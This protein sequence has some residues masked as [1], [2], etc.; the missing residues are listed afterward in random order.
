MNNVIWKPIKGYEGLYEISSTGQIK[1]LPRKKGLKNGHYYITKEKILKT[2]MTTTGYRKIELT[3][4]GTKK[5]KKVHRLIAKAFIP[6]EEG[7]PNINHIDGNQLNNNISNLEWCTQRE[8]IIHAYSIGLRETFNISK[9]ELEE[10]YVGQRK[11]MR[12]IGDMKNTTATVIQ[13]RIKEYGIKPRSLSEAKI[14][15]HITKEMLT[16]GL[17]NKTQKQLADEIGCEQSLISYYL[18]RIKEKGRLYG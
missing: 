12:E 17:K 7:K 6:N 1:S 10:L 14:E 16:E 15:Y 13:N 11:S 3:K 8:N 9:E 5:S 4:N 18:K 2:S